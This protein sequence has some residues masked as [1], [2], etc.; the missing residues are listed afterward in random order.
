VN[1]LGDR[2]K[3]R[4]LMAVATVDQISQGISALREEANGNLDPDLVA[5]AGVALLPA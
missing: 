4:P 3:P 1:Q 5:Q 2:T